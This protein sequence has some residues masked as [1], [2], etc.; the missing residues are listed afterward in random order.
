VDNILCVFQQN[1]FGTSVESE[2]ITFEEREQA[3]PMCGPGFIKKTCSHDRDYFLKSRPRLSF[4]D[5]STINTAHDD[6]HW[7]SALSE[8]AFLPSG[9]NAVASVDGARSAPTLLHF[10]K[11]RVEAI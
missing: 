9:K 2:Y 4:L 10:T 7:C 1:I 3:R 8:P 5:S 11:G 6:I